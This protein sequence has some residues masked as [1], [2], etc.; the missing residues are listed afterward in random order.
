[1]RIAVPILAALVLAS[2]AKPADSAKIEASAGKVELGQMN[3][4]FAAALN[5][6]DAARAASCYAE[7][8]VLVPP[9]EPI[10]KGRANI[11]AYWKTAIESG[12]VRDASVETLD[13]AS[14]GSLGYEIGSFT[15]T[16]NGPNGEPVAER[17][18]Y[19]ELLRRGPD[20]KWYSIA[21]ET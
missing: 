4:D 3:R 21:G 14:S 7:D 5:A 18:R 13:A 12:G 20:G 16:S 6:R 15:L 8:A 19:V 1:M 11:E 2:C 9:G 17:G 10:V